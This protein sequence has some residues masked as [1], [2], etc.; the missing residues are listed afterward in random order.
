MCVQSSE[1]C[2]FCHG[3]VALGVR[4]RQLRAQGHQLLPAIRFSRHASDAVG[5]RRRPSLPKGSDS[6]RQQRPLLRCR[7]GRV[8]VCMN[9]TSV[10]WG[11]QQLVSVCVLASAGREEAYFNSSTCAADERCARC[12]RASRA[13]SISARFCCRLRSA[14]DST[15]YRAPSNENHIALT[16]LPLRSSRG[17]RARL[18][19]QRLRCSPCP[20]PQPPAIQIEN[21]PVTSRLLSSRSKSVVAGDPNQ[22]PNPPPRATSLLPPMAEKPDNALAER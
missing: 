11:V 3:A 20:V 17:V 7:F 8:R 2:Q 22:Q 4:I 1:D 21:A 9:R 5:H 14:A 18:A 19:G 6:T 15:A 12:A 13:S 10:C 16:P